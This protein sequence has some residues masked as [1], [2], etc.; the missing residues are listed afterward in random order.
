MFV[1]YSFIELK[2]R[3]K[4][5][6][7]KVN[8]SISLFRKKHISIIYIIKSSYHRC[9]LFYFNKRSLKL[10]LSYLKKNGKARQLP[11]EWKVF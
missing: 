6:E 8:Y 7:N 3:K 4:I 2:K 9:I 10:S 11:V 5:Y 1:K